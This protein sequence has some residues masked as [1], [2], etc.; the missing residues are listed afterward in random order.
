MWRPEIDPEF[1][2]VRRGA[3]RCVER[4]NV[5]ARNRVRIRIKLRY[6]SRVNDNVCS[7]VYEKHL[8]SL[9]LKTLVIK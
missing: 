4:F 1:G 3:E 5:E 8:F 2:K 7:S 9:S 6:L